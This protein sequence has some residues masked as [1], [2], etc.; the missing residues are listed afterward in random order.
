MHATQSMTVPA[1]PAPP[2]NDRTRGLREQWERIASEVGA[3]PIALY[4][5]GRHTRM[6]LSCVEGCV[7]APTVAFI[8]DDAAEGHTMIRGIPVVHPSRAAPSAVALVVVSSDSVEST[9]AQ[10]AQDWVRASGS[11]GGAPRVHRLYDESSSLLARMQAGAEQNAWGHASRVLRDHLP[12]SPDARVL[13]L[14]PMGEPADRDFP[15]PPAELRAGYSPSNDAAYLESGRRDVQAIRGLIAARTPG[16]PPPSRVLDWGCS[17]GR[18]IRHWD[19]VANTGGEV[20]GCD[21]CAT[22]VRWASEHLSRRLRFFNSTTRPHLPL[23]DGCLD[24]VYGNSVFTHIR[25]LWD[26]WLLELRRVVRP[27][28]LVHTT[29]LDETSW[30]SVSRTPANLIRAQ[31]FDLDFSSP[32]TDDMVSHGSGSDIVT[33]WHTRGV[34]DRWSAFFDLLAIEPNAV[35]HQSAV[36]LRRRA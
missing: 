34:R 29:I 18:M 12:M 24:L 3:R 19:D 21:I 1:R 9:L 4:G 27:G 6:L 22:S 31:C 7:K 30:D 2:S 32:L 14:P 8:L 15:L 16:S 26:A 5:A 11:P 20:W 35:G 28:G 36:L 17:T 25:E 13:R 23:E 33:F 10:R